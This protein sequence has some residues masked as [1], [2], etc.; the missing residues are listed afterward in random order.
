MAACLQTKLSP[1]VVANKVAISLEESAGGLSGGGLPCA[2]SRP[3][4][5]EAEGLRSLGGL[6]FI[7]AQVEAERGGSWVCWVAQNKDGNH[8]KLLFFSIQLHV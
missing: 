1:C 7:T 8:K 5:A 3:R 4:N 6:H 2:L